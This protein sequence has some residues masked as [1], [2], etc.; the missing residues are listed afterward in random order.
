MKEWESVFLL[1]KGV[2]YYSKSVLYYI[3][4]EKEVLYY[5]HSLEES[6]GLRR[7]EKDGEGVYVTEYISCENYGVIYPNSTSM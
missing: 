6:L 1:Y 5:I 3:W 4:R 7:I 2:I